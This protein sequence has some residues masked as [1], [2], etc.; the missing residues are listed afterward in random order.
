MSSAPISLFAIVGAA[1][2]TPGP[3]NMIVMTLAA[4]QG[5]SAASRALIGVLSGLLL[6]L[7]IAYFGLTLLRGGEALVTLVVSTLGSVYFAWLGYKLIVAPQG[8][9]EHRQS[10]P[11]GALGVTGFQLVNPKAW[12]LAMTVA[13]AAGGAGGFWI[14]TSVTLLISGLCLCIWALSGMFMARALHSPRA[15]RLFEIAIGAVLAISA[16]LLAVDAWGGLT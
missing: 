4:R 13:A 3:N 10:L 11:S 5:L 9:G 8:A 12:M 1:A 6:L 14:A 16:L 7:V 2:I 15:S